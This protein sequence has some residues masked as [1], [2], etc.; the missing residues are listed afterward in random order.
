MCGSPDAEA[1]ATL[2]AAAALAAYMLASSWALTM[3][4]FVTDSL[5]A[6]PIVHLKGHKECIGA[7]G[8]AIFSS[9]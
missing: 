6:E 9:R 7:F 2:P 4:L 5:V 3:F 1:D 8:N